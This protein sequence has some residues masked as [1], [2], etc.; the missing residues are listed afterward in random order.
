MPASTKLTDAHARSLSKSTMLSSLYVANFIKPE[1]VIRVLN[2]AQIDFVLAGAHAL[3]GWIGE[4]RATQDVDVIISTRLVRKAVRVLLNAFHELQERDEGVVV[5]LRNPKTSEVSID[6]M[7]TDQPIFKAALKNTQRV[8]FA[9]R[10]YKIP[11]LEMALALKFVPMVSPNREDRKKYM[12][13]HDFISI[14][15][16][17]PTIDLDKLSTLGELIYPGGGKEIVEIV[18]RV[19]AGERLKL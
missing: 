4:P 3:G 15:K 16:K 19:R 8:R 12:D 17:N 7:K 14:V 6:V 18:R 11:S 5:R 13:A 1:D 10:T 9:R 2:A